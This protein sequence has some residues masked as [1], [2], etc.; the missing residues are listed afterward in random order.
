MYLKVMD[1]ILAAVLP[2]ARNISKKIAACQTM[3]EFKGIVPGSDGSDV[4]AD[5]THCPVQRPSEKTVRC[6]M[7][8]GKKK[9]FTYNTTI[10]TNTDGP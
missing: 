2:T 1:R 6:M 9:R 3:E 4:I 7:Y 8:S 10:F 5:C